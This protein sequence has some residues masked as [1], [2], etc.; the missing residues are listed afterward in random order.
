MVIFKLLRF[1][2]INV[3]SLFIIK[4]VLQKA[5]LGHQNK[6]NLN[7]KACVNRYRDLN[8]NVTLLAYC[9]VQGHGHS[10]E[11]NAEQHEESQHFVHR[12]GLLQLRRLGYHRASGTEQAVGEDLRGCSGSPKGRSSREVLVVQR[13]RLSLHREEDGHRELSRMFASKAITLRTQ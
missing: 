4:Y 6:I 10:Q 3:S 2:S 7:G 5:K 13:V 8:F 1:F 11:W 12:R 9:K